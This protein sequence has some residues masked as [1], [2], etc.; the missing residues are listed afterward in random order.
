MTVQ[1]YMS[2]SATNGFAIGNDANNGL[3][4]ATPKLTL[5]GVTT[6][7]NASANDSYALTINDGT[8]S[9]ATANVGSFKYNL[10]IDPVTDYGVT[11][12][13]AA[14]TTASFIA[15]NA[16]VASG[17]TLSLGK[18]IVDCANT[19]V[20]MTHAYEGLAL[21]PA[22][23]TYHAI[24]RGITFKNPRFRHVYDTR[25]TGDLI[26]WWNQ[27][28]DT[29]GLTGQRGSIIQAARV[30]G[31]I[32]IDGVY[33]SIIDA[34]VPGAGAILVDVTAVNTCACIVRNCTGVVTIAA[35]VGNGTY[36]GVRVNNIA[37]TIIE[38][39]DLAVVWGGSGTPSAYIYNIGS[40]MSV[41]SANGIIRKNK[42]F[43]GTTGGIMALI[44]SDATSVGD[45][46][47][48][49]GLIEDNI[50]TAANST[51]THGAML[52]NNTG[53]DIRANKVINCCIP[54]LRK[55]NTG[56]R[57]YGN[58]V[59]DPIG[60]YGWYS[61]GSTNG[62]F[63]NNDIIITASAQPSAVFSAMYVGINGT[64]NSTGIKA[65]NN[66]IYTEKLLPKLVNVA[67]GS[68]ATFSNN[69]YY[70]SLPLS[71]A[72]FSYQ[73][74]TY[75]SIAAWSAA[76]EST[77]LNINPNFD[78]SQIAKNAALSGSGKNQWWTST[79]RRPVGKNGEPFA[80]FHIS[81]GANQFINANHP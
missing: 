28:V 22:A 6:A 48:N 51:T 78:A 18:I 79:G 36:L 29:P 57:V 59:I 65:Y 32:A 41:S 74:S 45:N 21:T 23:N 69:N 72:S 5:A 13:I 62:G 25:T 35:G 34:S 8:Y 43:N 20:D 70:S 31:N 15:I 55:A 12:S 14:S 77:A 60:D 30:S 42:G 16:S 71:S 68:D 67:V 4:K 73:G 76:R 3:T 1:Y 9:V 37:Q 52:G 24:L 40:T 17:A 58:T 63:Y 81:I 19:A 46:Y 61:K 11:L 10:T 44:G 7:I 49:D 38:L 27:I 53:G 47:A 56:G 2:N 80:D 54:L 64:T 75:D 26:G 66:N 50:L 39:N 33:T